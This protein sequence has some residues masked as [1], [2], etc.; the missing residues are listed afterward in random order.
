LD[1]DVTSFSLVW[2]LFLQCVDSHKWWL[3]I[4]PNDD[5][6]YASIFLGSGSGS[7]WWIANTESPILDGEMLTCQV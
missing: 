6:I 3:L 5:I 1:E 7:W 4:S 2:L